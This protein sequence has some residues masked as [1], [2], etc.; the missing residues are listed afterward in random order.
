MGRLSYDDL[1]KILQKARGQAPSGL[2]IRHAASGG[3]YTVFSHAL[4]EAD[5]EPMIGYA[6]TD[7][8][9]GAR[10]QFVRPLTEVMAKFVPVETGEWPQ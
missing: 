7:S 3:I 1:E 6:L 5:L 10:V 8:G 4:R 9:K 2:A